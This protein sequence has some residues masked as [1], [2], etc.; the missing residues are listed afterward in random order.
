MVAV[1][2]AVMVVGLVGCLVGLVGRPQL[3]YVKRAREETK[4]KRTFDVRCVLP[5]I[6]VDQRRV[7]ITARTRAKSRAQPRRVEHLI[8]KNQSTAISGRWLILIA[9]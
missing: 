9:R 7:E 8:S 5:D 3:V 1:A 4:R 6:L 2:V